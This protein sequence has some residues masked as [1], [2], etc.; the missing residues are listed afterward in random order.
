MIDTHRS[1]GDPCPVTVFVTELSAHVRLFSICI[2]TLT[3]FAPEQCKCYALLGKLP[4][5][6]GVVRFDIGNHLVFL[7]RDAQYLV[8]L[9]IGHLII[10]RP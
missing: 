10:K 5:D 1:L 7:C 9:F 6:V 4:V 8:K 2:T 3:V